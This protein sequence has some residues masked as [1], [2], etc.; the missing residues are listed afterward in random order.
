[1]GRLHV[2]SGGSTP[3]LDKTYKRNSI[4]MLLYRDCHQLP[5]PHMGAPCSFRGNAQ[6]PPAPTQ[7]R[8][9]AG[10][11][12]NAAQNTE[13]AMAAITT[14]RKTKRAGAGRPARGERRGR[15]R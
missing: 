11:A 8:G 15:A 14:V 5:N 13:A 6:A 3:T 10:S 4:Q 1:M 12:M 9:E 2:L 7:A